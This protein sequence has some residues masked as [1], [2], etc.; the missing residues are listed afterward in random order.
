[1]SR[2]LP[3]T[4]LESIQQAAARKAVHPDTIRR[5]ISTG[6]LKAHR[7]GRQIIRVEVAAVDALFAPIPTVERAS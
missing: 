3:E 6:E 5:R 2:G 7:L 4:P 1:V